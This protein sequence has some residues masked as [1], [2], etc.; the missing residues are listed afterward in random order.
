MEIIK[1]IALAFYTLTILLP[2]YLG[3]VGWWY[4][5]HPTPF[6]KKYCKRREG[7]MFSKD[8][9]DYRSDNYHP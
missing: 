1:Y 5:N 4:R 9:L 8:D 7:S 3:L 6:E 2:I